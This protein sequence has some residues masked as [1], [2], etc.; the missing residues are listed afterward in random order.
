MPPPSLWLLLNCDS[1]AARVDT[2]RVS[3]HAFI[4]IS[5]FKQLR[6][7]EVDLCLLVVLQVHTFRGP[8]WCEYC[9]NFMWGLIAQ[10]V[11]CAGK[12]THAQCK[13]SIEN[14]L[15][16]KDP[17]GHFPK[18]LHSNICLFKL[19]L[20]RKTLFLIKFLSRFLNKLMISQ[21]HNNVLQRYVISQGFILVKH[22][23][24][25]KIHLK[26]HSRSSR[27]NGKIKQT[28]PITVQN[29]GSSQPIFIVFTL[30]HVLILREAIISTCS[31]ESLFLSLITTRTRLAKIT[32]PNS[33]LLLCVKPLS[34]EESYILYVWR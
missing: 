34:L 27:A 25:T 8:H 11:K 26:K 13:I 33:F 21:L 17:D 31:G 23:N 19:G 10:G 15:S 29:A 12:S 18:M 24:K 7:A 16:T 14:M 30:F 28:V 3:N 5:R 20:M 9:A 32:C 22:E 2:A 1:T 4:F 6:G